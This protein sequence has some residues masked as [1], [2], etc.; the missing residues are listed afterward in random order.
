MSRLCLILFGAPGSGKGTQAKLLKQSLGVAHISTG[1]MLRERIASGD[2]L[3]LEVE[4]IMKAGS[5][6]SDETVNRL[7]EE[8]IEEPDAKSGFILDGFPRTVTQA[9][10]LGQVLKA[11][12]IVPLVMHLKVDYNVIIARLS[13]RRLCPT[14]GNLY[15]VTPNV[16]AASEVCDY[17]GTK[18]VVREDDREDV[19]RARLLAYEQQT[20]PV[21]ACLKQAGYPSWDLEG[22][23]ESPH[24]IA[25]KIETLIRNYQAGAEEARA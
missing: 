10:L 1:D 20:E 3:G 23:G 22:A 4:S 11:K 18:L 14:C 2:P 5:L 24:A 25:R 8:R 17:D 13:G 21:L 19:V 7:V 6:V 16:Q 15:S 12:G 9:K